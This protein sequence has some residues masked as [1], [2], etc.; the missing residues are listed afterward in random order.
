MGSCVGYNEI[1]VPYYSNFDMY[2]LQQSEP[3]H[4]GVACDGSFKP[5]AHGG[6]LAAGVVHFG[7]SVTL[8]VV[9]PS[10]DVLLRH[11]DVGGTSSIAELFAMACSVSLLRTVSLPRDGLVM[12]Y[13]DKKEL[14]GT[15]CGVLGGVRTDKSKQKRQRAMLA[16]PEV[17]SWCWCMIFLLEAQKLIVETGCR[18]R[19]QWI[20]VVGI[21]VR[22]HIWHMP[23]G[24]LN[25]DAVLQHDV[26]TVCLGDSVIRLSVA[27]VLERVKRL[28]ESDMSSR[29][30]IAMVQQQ[31]VEITRAAMLGEHVVSMDLSIC[32]KGGSSLIDC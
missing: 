20:S 23:V 12:L 29:S 19:V 11:D 7:H 6:V 2:R 8:K 24:W 26:E 27:S 1:V 10:I 16:K 31:P 3:F 15:F 5:N 30:L 18:L 14:L 21:V 32:T 25:P 4:L 9:G 22:N 17:A 13:I 28:S